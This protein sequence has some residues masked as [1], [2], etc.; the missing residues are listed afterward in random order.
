[1]TIRR[2]RD[3]VSSVE[4]SAGTSAGFGSGAGDGVREEWR[5]SLSVK[6]DREGSLKWLSFAL[7]LSTG[8]SDSGASQNAIADAECASRVTPIL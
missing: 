8:A 5:W 6:W 2:G 1:M 4:A 3:F 7:S